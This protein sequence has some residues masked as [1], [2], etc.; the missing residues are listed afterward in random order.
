LDT[1]KL[2]S[3]SFW[4][5]LAITLFADLF[6]VLVVAAS[7]Q[8]SHQ[9]YWERAATTSRNTN[10]LV[11]QGI[12]GEIEQIDQGLRSVVD[13]FARERSAGGLH[14][15]TMTGYLRRLQERLPMT[16][17][18]RIADAQGQIVSGS[19]PVL[20]TGVSI[21]DR[22]Y[23]TRLKDA[24]DDP[25]A[26]SPPVLGKISGKW[27]VIFSRRLAP[28]GQDFPGV[29]FAAVPIDWF[30]KL[31]AR[32]DIGPQGVVVLRGNATRNFDII[33]RYPHQPALVG[34]TSVS[35][36]FRSLITANPA[37]G[38]YEAVA[39]GDGVRRIFAY[40]AVGPHPLVTLVGLSTE[41]TM[42]PW[43][44]EAEKLIALAV[45]F[46]ML[47]ALGCWAIAR[48]W[49][50]R[51]RAYREISLLNEEL[52][53]DNAARRRAEG[54]ALRLNAEL[55]QRVHE[56]TAQLE[57]A[58]QE[59]ILA[60]DAADTAS[61][62]K[63]AFLANMSH[64]IRTPLNAISGMAHLVRREG[65]S[66]R[67]AER[68]DKLE[69]ASQH[70]IEVINAVLDLSKIEAGK[71]SLEETSVSP[72]QL[73]GDAA[74]ML[75]DKAEAKH[76]RLVT[77]CGTLP[78]SL[79]GDPTRLQQAL[80]NYAT[81]AIKFTDQGEVTLRVALAAEDS[82]TALLRFEVTDTGIGIA[83]EAMGKLF[84]AFEQADNSTTR[85]Y[86]GTGLG[87]AITGKLA[88]L[89]GG[90]AGAESTLGVGSR[91]WFTARL[92][93]GPHLNPAP[94]PLADEVEAQLRRSHAGKSILLVED[95]PINQEIAQLMLEDVGLTVTIAENGAVAL[96]LA[97]GHDFA[98]ILMDMQMPEM[99]GIEA[100]QR[101]RQLPGRNATPILAMTANVFA[102]DKQ[103]C[104]AAGMDDFIPKP[105]EP[106]QLYATL[107]VW[108]NR[109]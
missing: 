1:H 26:L 84:S 90:E 101:I 100:T 72:G 99:D 80:L 63:S 30:E 8:A 87:L 82:G 56:R 10:R 59:L 4:A 52:A 73:L 51:A 89:M 70:L 95:E 104:F 81:N 43:R 102:E 75:R 21:A 20:P 106:R 64:E 69:S 53:Q 85:K 68:M 108:L 78:A 34:Q 109:P 62:A 67:Q 36:Q 45:T 97:A 60:R 44:R 33:A 46:V 86:G 6:V 32:L 11:A 83:P 48:S 39:A 93:K 41:D 15:P 98:V 38:S 17:S 58:N 2:Y 88:Q 25:L 23:F 5:L 19:D 107:A 50:A 29:V 57:S 28:S 74:A 76:L 35:A 47:S 96:D 71:L 13:E 105:I 54:E 66:P 3:K 37:E 22:E 65:L 12:Q 40:Q 49:L 24:A 42:V 9:H 61:Q 14:I 27:V 55:E 77:E 7:L 31:F 79:L 103:R 91:F 92:R 94:A 18:L 16:D